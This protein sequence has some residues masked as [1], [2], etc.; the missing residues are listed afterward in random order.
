[1]LLI[2]LILYVYIELLHRNAK[3]GHRTPLHTA[4]CLGHCS[5]VECLITSGAN[6]NVVDIVSFCLCL[7]H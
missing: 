2:R 3:Q 4:A 1:M 5:V 6:V 7:L